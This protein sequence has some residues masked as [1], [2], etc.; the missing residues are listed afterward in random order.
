[1]FDILMTVH[2]WY[3]V[4]AAPLK[5]KPKP[6]IWVKLHFDILSAYVRTF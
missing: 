6:T 4:Q 1:M 2:T 5:F 3:F